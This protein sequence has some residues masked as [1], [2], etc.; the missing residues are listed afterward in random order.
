MIAGIKLLGKDGI[1]GKLGNE[2]RPMLQHARDLGN[3]RICVVLV[4][5]QPPNCLRAALPLEPIPLIK[6]P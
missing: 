4:A 3:Q 6:S 2:E 1:E 5:P